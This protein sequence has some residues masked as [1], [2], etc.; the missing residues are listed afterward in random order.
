M[1]TTAHTS[2]YTFSQSWLGL[3]CVEYVRNTPAIEYKN[4]DIKSAL[5]S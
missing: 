3:L 4:Q 1:K 5:Y 2:S